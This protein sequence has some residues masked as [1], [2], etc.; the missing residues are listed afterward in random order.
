MKNLAHTKTFS[1][2]LLS[3]EEE[4]KKNTIANIPN[5]ISDQNSIRKHGYI[6]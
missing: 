1:H 4:Q 3:Q 2:G 5:E 6:A